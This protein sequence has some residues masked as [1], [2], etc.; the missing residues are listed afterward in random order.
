MLITKFLFLKNYFYD[1]GI[2]GTPIYFA[3]EIYK[4]FK[5]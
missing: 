3:P 4:L 5:E 2:K 1:L